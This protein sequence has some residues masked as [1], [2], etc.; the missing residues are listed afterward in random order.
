MKVLIKIGITACVLMAMT[1]LMT[2]CNSDGKYKVEGD[3][4]YFT[5]WTFSFGTIKEPL[6]GCDAETFQSVKDWLGRDQE[7]V[8]F[9]SRLVKGADPASVEVDRF[10]LFHDKHDYYYRGAA[11]GV[12]DLKT[13]R[14]LKCDEDEMWGVDS[15][16]VYFDSLRIEN[17]DPATLELI[18]TFEAK[19]K[20]H[21]Y[22]FGKILEGADPATYTPVGKYSCYTKDRTHV[23]HCGEI[24]KD[25]D[26]STF[27]IE[28][29]DEF[30]MPDAHDKNRKY[31]NGKP[32]VPEEERVEEA[33]EPQDTTEYIIEE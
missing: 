18:S 16:Y 17:S 13:F 20:R 23:W 19:D 9:K 27:E 31:R 15:R 12:A 25:A 21:V 8:W 32:W 33:E 10:P 6:E 24:V 14:T 28:K 4:V 29:H 3:S 11:V 5:Y 22:Y 26:P 1:V 7:H 2:G 30:D